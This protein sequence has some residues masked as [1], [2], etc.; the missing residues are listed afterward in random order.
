MNRISACCADL[1]LEMT[2]Q[3]ECPD[4]V[5]VMACTQSQLQ[6]LAD[7]ASLFFQPDA[8]RML[9]AAVPPIDN[10]QLRKS[11]ELPF[12]SDW[13]VSRF[14]T[15]TLGW[16]TSTVAAARQS[17]FGLFRFSAR[18][19]PRYY[20][21][22]NGNAFELP[23]QIG[24]YIVIRKARRSVLSYCADSKTLCMPVTCRPPLLIDRALTLC[25]GLIPEFDGGILTYR[26]ID[27][28]IALAT[29]RLLRQWRK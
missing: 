23:V 17:P 13:D 7:R 4:R 9:L 12:G 22:L 27:S 6:Q 28:E 15:T 18:F 24:K 5:Q 3:P 11:S 10:Y 20:L 16:T 29:F 19:Q 26:N 8:P 14:S 21:K 1:N 2:A 25:S